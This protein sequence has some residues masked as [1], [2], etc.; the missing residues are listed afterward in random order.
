MTHDFQVLLGCDAP[1]GSGLGRSSSVIV[2]LLG[3]VNEYT[4]QRIEPAELARLAWQIERQDL[5]L[6]GGLQDYYS[7]IY[8]G[9][10]YIRF[11]DSAVEVQP[12]SLGS[13]L[14]DD[15]E[16][17]LLLCFLNQTRD[18]GKIIEAQT[19]RVTSGNE[20]T[21][22]AMVRQ[23][24]YA[25]EMRKLLEAG[26]LDDI[27]EL[28]HEVWECKK[29]F[30]PLISSPFIDDAY[31]VARKHGALGGK[32]SGAGG[33]GFL[34]LY[35]PLDCRLEVATAMTKV[36]LR[37]DAVKLDQTG[38]RTWTVGPPPIRGQR[39]RVHAKRGND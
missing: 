22:A 38:L 27:G 29:N 34:L 30:L 3:L 7:A 33:G 31:A 5:G 12:L 2:A 14:L 13:G 9:L 18:S 1:P 15:L 21:L 39:M 32:L 36:G 16:D 37:T 8:G 6:P 26:R 11:D 17:R 10:N 24:T 20:E 19:E 23:R 28:L 4:E 25:D 35:T